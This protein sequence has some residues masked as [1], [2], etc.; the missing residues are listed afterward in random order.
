[1]D[2]TLVSIDN[3][4]LP[5][6]ERELKRVLLRHRGGGATSLPP[7]ERELKRWLTAE[8]VKG[9]KS[10]PPRERELKLSYNIEQHMPHS[11]APPA[12]A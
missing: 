7:R 12:G 2:N 9:I 10:L 5:P 4:A 8:I 11:V 6:R 1:M 3:Q